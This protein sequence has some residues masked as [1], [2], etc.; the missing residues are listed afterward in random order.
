MDLDFTERMVKKAVD[1]ADSGY[2]DH[3]HNKF[4]IFTLAAGQAAWNPDSYMAHCIGPATVPY[5]LHLNGD[6][7]A[8]LVTWSQQP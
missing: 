8:S 6:V 7:S 4:A 1:D 3:S 2:P 5:T